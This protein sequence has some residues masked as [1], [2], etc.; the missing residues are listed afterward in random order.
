VGIVVEEPG[1]RDCLSLTSFANKNAK[2]RRLGDP[3]G[4]GN[5][6]FV[7]GMLGN[8]AEVNLFF[9][10]GHGEDYTQKKLISHLLNIHLTMTDDKKRRRKTQFQDLEPGIRKDIVEY[11]QPTVTQQANLKAQY[12][13]MAGDRNALKEFEEMGDD[14][15]FTDIVRRQY[16]RSKSWYHKTLERIASA[17]GKWEMYRYFWDDSK[18]FPDQGPNP[19][20]GGS[21]PLTT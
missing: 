11:L 21:G 16:E 15:M 2:N 20:A 4:E 10:G 19:P 17:P 7:K 14:P 12:A 9:F 5:L 6:V 13:V 8:I 18:P 1:G 3:L